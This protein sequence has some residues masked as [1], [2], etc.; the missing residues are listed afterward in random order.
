MIRLRPTGLIGLIG[1]VV[2]LF[3]GEYSMA[4]EQRRNLPQEYQKAIEAWRSYT[5]RPEIQE[6]S[7]TSAYTNNE[8]YAHI[9]SLGPDVLPFLI[10]D[11]ERGEFLL[12][13]AV[14]RIT[15]LDVR[16]LY[17]QQKVVGEQ[18]ISKLWV[19]WWREK[20]GSRRNAGTDGKF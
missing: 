15:G 13:D 6:S 11:L 12:N 19:R 9:V 1:T 17:P 3:G 4:E 10:A 20:R 14:R 18:D 16:K 8:A 2:Y 5:Q 7:Q